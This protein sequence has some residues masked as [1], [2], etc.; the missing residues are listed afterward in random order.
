MA[1]AG[2]KSYEEANA[3][4]LE[5][6]QSVAEEIGSA[7]QKLARKLRISEAVITNIDTECKRMEEKAYQALLKWYHGRG[8]AS[9]TK[10]VLCKALVAVGETIIA[11]KI[12]C[13]SGMSKPRYGEKFNPTSFNERC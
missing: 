13:F 6:I 10:K 12:G 2:A 4:M 3:R 1:G 11:E 9:A 7:W 8:Q 5:N